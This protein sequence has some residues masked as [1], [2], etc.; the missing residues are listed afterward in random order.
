MVTIVFNNEVLETNTETIKYTKQVND[1]AELETRQTSFTDS[2]DL[3][4]TPQITQ[5]FEHLGI[6]G[7]YSKTPYFKNDVQLFDNGTPLIQKGWLNVIE[8]NNKGYKCNIYDGIIDFFK[9]IENKTMGE[10]LDLSE[11]DH[12]KTIENVVASFGNTLNYKYIV[13]DYGG[14]THLDTLSEI[15][16]DYLIPSTNIK[17]L[18]DKIF[19][20]FGFEYDGDVFDTEDFQGLWLTYP[21]AT[22]LSI[23]D[24]SVLFAELKIYNGFSFGFKNIIKGIVQYTLNERFEPNYYAAQTETYFVPE[25]GYYNI[26]FKIASIYGNIDDPIYLQINGTNYNDT[27]GSINPTQPFVVINK[28]LNKGDTLRFSTSKGSYKPLDGEMTIRKFN[29]EVSFSEGLKE[30]S[31]TDF[32]KE[33]IWRFSLTIFTDID[34]KL[35]F[36][37]FDERLNAEVIDWSEKYIDRTA[38]TYTLNSY[39]QRNYFTHKYNDSESSFNNGVF[40]IENKN[41]IESK[42]SI[43]SKIFSPERL[44][45]N[46]KINNTNNEITTPTLIWQ[47]E[48]TENDDIQKVKYKELSSRFYFIR[49]ENINETC[50]LASSNL[51][52]SQEI[53]SIP[54][55]RFVNTTFKDFVPKYYRDIKLL[56]DDFRMHKINLNLDYLDVLNLDFYKIYYFAQES[57]YYVLNKMNYETNKSAKAEFLRVK[58]KEQ[59]TMDYIEITSTEPIVTGLKVFFGIL[60][61]SINVNSVT[62]QIKHQNDTI[63]YDYTT[64]TTSPLLIGDEYDP[65]DFMRLKLIY[66]DQNIAFSNEI[67]L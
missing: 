16:I 51:Q 2:F 52:I 66:N 44:F 27:R 31:I 21:K 57:N 3:P 58:Y 28:L 34:G 4:K 50:T 26:K 42:N 39:G 23:I 46:F 7:D 40:D 36:K 32:I 24:D 30:L 67:T 14:K 8:T 9:A 22:P 18:W 49:Y 1:I 25:N 62:I 13:N 45:Q 41:L 64:G 33:I 35:I 55:A 37:T 43:E 48:V 63:W 12:D 6:V 60:N 56:L 53:S 61:T 29:S 10:S 20:T 5:A 38:E 65:G 11:I 19:T 47:K 15:N 54:F 59:F 17:F